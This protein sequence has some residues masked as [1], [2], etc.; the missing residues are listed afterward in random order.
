MKKVVLVS[1]FLMILI[2]PV[3]ANYEVTDLG[4]FEGG[5]HMFATNINNSGKVCGYGF[6]ETAVQAF[7]SDI[8]PIPFMTEAYG[9]SDN[10][11]I[12]GM[13]IFRQR[14]LPSIY[15]NGKTR[16]LGTLGG[17]FGYAK[18]IHGRVIVG[19]AGKRCGN[20][21]VSRPCLWIG[22]RPFELFNQPGIGW[23]NGIN[24]ARQIVGTFFPEGQ[25]P[26]AFF[27]QKGRVKFLGPGYAQAINNRR[28]VV[29]WSY[30]DDKYQAMLWRRTSEVLP[31]FE[32][33]AWATNVNNKGEIVGLAETPLGFRGVI[34]KENIITDLNEL[35]DS[36][37]WVVFSAQAINNRG[38]IAC[39]GRNINDNTTHALLLTPF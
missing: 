30:I 14:T 4:T 35:F 28:W 27:W 13:T 9:I 18:A 33:Q 29:G 23:A 20:V 10:G 19:S 26:L 36:D 15:K 5:G 11:I 6:T 16:L 34:W 21:E 32:G 37:E 12:V 22:R 17:S 38:Q 7:T 25:G 39:R 24:N 8:S 3:S 1:V 31:S 2:Q